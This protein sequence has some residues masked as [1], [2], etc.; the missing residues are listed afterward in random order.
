MASFKQQ[1]GAAALAALAAPAAL[2]QEGGQGIA[3]PFGECR[4]GYW[5]SSRDLDDNTGVAKGTCFVNWKHAFH[6]RW[7]VNLGSRLGVRDAGGT[8]GGRNRLREA[9]L[10]TDAGPLR[11]RLGRQLI[12]WGRADRINPT[13]NLSPRDYTA[14]APEDEEQ[15]IGID[16]LAANYRLGDSLELAAVLVPEF[17]PHRTPQGS[18]PSNRAVAPAP[19]GGEWAFKLEKS[20]GAWDGSVSYYDGYDRFVRYGAA[21]PRPATLVFSGAHERMR[22]VGADFSTTALGWGVR[23]EFAAGSFSPACTGCGGATRSVRRLVLGVDRDIG[24]SANLNLQAFAIR[25]SGYAET[26]GLPAQ[27]RVAGLA[28]N[29]LNSE[30]GA[31]EHGLSLRVYERYWND[32]LKAELGAIVDLSGHSGLVRPRVSYSVSDAVKL[33]AGLDYFHGDAQSFFGARARNRLGFFELAFV[34]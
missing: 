26:A 4:A 22:T 14:L 21:L 24:D 33:T 3:A 34:F 25:R 28:I 32:R 15:R 19:D 17:E 1:L 9:Y 20:G 27:L 18:L 10:E 16:A 8:R 31:H 11:L 12:A 7:R 23:G 29:R 13:D 2:A 30:F 6:E 5:S